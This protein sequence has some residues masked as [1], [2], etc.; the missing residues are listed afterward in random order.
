MTHVDP[1]LLLADACDW[2][3]REEHA[4]VAAHLDKCPDCLD[5]FAGYCAECTILEATTR[6]RG[7]GRSRLLIAAAIIPF[8]LILGAILWRSA[9][10]QPASRSGAAPSVPSPVPEA[11][12]G[13]YSYLGH[14]YPSREVSIFSKVQALVERVEVLRGT[15]V[16]KGD[17]LIQLKAP[18]LLALAEEA[19]VRLTQDEADVQRLQVV[20]SKGLATQHELEAEKSKVALD[21]AHL[22]TCEANLSYLRIVAPFDGIIADRAVEEGSLVGPPAGAA[23]PALLRLQNVDRLRLTVSLPASSEP[24]LDHVA[25]GDRVIFV[26]RDRLDQK[27]SGLYLGSTRTVD[28]ATGTFTVDVEVDNSSHGLLPGMLVFVGWPPPK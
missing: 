16:K 12:D 10:S 6:P 8:G 9:N 14:L 13:A 28:P 5:R 25:P 27:M 15:Q 19:R 22:S 11:M 26:L 23:P 20:V 17:L 3:S 21:K 18:E 24:T 7:S 1:D 4:Q 2:T